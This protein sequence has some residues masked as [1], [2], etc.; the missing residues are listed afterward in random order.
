MRAEVSARGRRAGG[1]AYIKAGP[2]AGGAQSGQRFVAEPVTPTAATSR[3]S[4]YPFLEAE[5]DE[6]ETDLS[7]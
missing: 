4:R 1:G 5:R 2:A 7:L 3:P 6:P